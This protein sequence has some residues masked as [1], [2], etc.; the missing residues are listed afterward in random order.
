M[1]YMDFLTYMESIFH[2]YL[3]NINMQEKMLT[4]LNETDDKSKQQKDVGLTNC[5]NQ[6]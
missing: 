1:F 5:A 4:W 2:Y 6:I 3:Y